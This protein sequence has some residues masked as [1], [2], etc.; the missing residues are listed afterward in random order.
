MFIRTAKCNKIRIAIGIL[1]TFCL[2]SV[3]HR[4]QQWKYVVNNALFIMPLI[5]WLAQED[6]KE[7]FIPIWSD[8]KII[9]TQNNH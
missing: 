7:L 2:L 6:A 9:R 1:Y 4:A 8:L 5:I 3:K